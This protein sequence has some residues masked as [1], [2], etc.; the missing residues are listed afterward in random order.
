MADGSPAIE[1]RIR[2]Y[3][4]ERGGVED[5]AGRGLT[6]EMA[7]FLGVDNPATLSVTLAEMERDDL[8]TR[9]TRGLRTFRIALVG[10]AGTNNAPPVSPESLGKGTDPGSPPA[11][12]AISLRDALAAG[13]AEAAAPTGSPL[14]PPNYAAETYNSPRVPPDGQGF[15][16]PQYSYGP[17]TGPYWQPQ[18]PR[19]PRS[20]P[21]A[22]ASLVLGLL[23]FGPLLLV[24]SIL[25]IA[26]GFSGLQEIDRSGGAQRGKG[27]AIAGIALGI[28]G[29][30]F[31]AG[32]V[33]LVMS[34]HEPAPCLRLEGDC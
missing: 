29:F 25:A 24:G 20:N 32:L 19:G 31:I 4:A 34:R 17:P 26:L 9:A 23:G 10:P 18:P 22:T 12:R 33:L 15:P 1:E 16:P 7:R 2:S 3:L 6:D 28:L 8:I 11:A 21:T 30:L 13:G 5:P 14:P 27:R